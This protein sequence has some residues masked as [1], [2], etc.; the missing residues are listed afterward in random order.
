MSRRWAWIGGAC[1]GMLLV[2]MGG[3]AAA[4]IERPL[5]LAKLIEQAQDILVAKVE[6]V[7]PDRPS[8]VLIADKDLKGKTAHRRMPINLTGDKEKHTPQ[9]LK[10]VAADLPI[11]LFT[12]DGPDQIV[13]LAYTN[14]TWFQV[15]GHKDGQA[16]RWAFTHCEI[17][18]RRTYKG[19]TEELLKVLTDALAGKKQPPELD[20]NEPPGFGPELEEKPKGQARSGAAGGLLLGVV[21]LPFLMP[22]A[23]LLQLLFPGLL[24]DQW[25]QYKVAV[26]ILLTQST[27][28]FIHLALVRWV[29]SE[30]VWWLSDNAL[31]AALVTVALIGA[32]WAVAKRQSPPAVG[33]VSRPVL[34][35]APGGPSHVLDHRPVRVEYVAFGILAFAGLGWAGYLL[36]SSQ[37]P[38]DQMSVIT[39]ASL[40]GIA[41]LIYRRVRAAR[42]TCR[43]RVS[44]EAVFL[45]GLVLAGV[46]VGLY[47][48]APGEANAETDAVAADW[49]M[50][51]GN[52]QRTGSAGSSDAE[53]RKPAILWAFDAKDR[54]P[55][56]L[57]SSPVVVDGLVYV[58]ALH[59]ALSLAQGCLYC[60]NAD[61]GRLVSDRTFAAGERI[62]RFPPRGYLKPVFSS[63]SI[64]N[65][66]LYFGE[67]YHEDSGCRLFCLDARSGNQALWAKKTTS[68]VESGPCVVGNRIYFGAGDDGIYCVDADQLEPGE[69]DVPS[70][71]TLWRLPGLHV[72]S[73]P[74][75]VDDRL[76]AA[77]VIGDLHRELCLVA[78]DAGS[79][80]IVWKLPVA[81]PA[82]AAPAH[83]N[84]RV[85]F[86]LGAGKVNEAAADSRGAAICLDANGDFPKRLWEY[87]ADSAVLATPA[88]AG[89]SVF[90]CSRRG[91]CYALRQSDGH[92][93][94]KK[95][96][97]GG[98]VASPVVAGNRL[99]V[100]TT[101]GFLY[102]L[103]LADGELVWRFDE[104]KRHA[105]DDVYSSPTLVDGRL[106]LAAGGKLFC[107][108]DSGDP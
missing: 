54:M 66:R 1:F 52:E 60:V 19:T 14:G 50:F 30:Q 8:M 61:D 9:L 97:D 45:W 87:P 100:L 75:V 3:P 69:E 46:G 99:Y 72:D 65:G 11:I 37:P 85:F 70:P 4:F 34:P 79:G 64:A 108:G 18:L 5:P 80:R 67:G 88:L 28:Y 71:K 73:C 44:T 49:P 55:A 36:W 10:R 81:L 16:V 2:V 23:A 78:V 39:L 58:G 13:V 56:R 26:Y 102:C 47:F 6:K 29:F 40:V 106:Y 91:W 96:L 59:E 104:L 43:P 7:D 38:I 94:W 107:I 17:Y 51:R 103:N 89:E 90:I 83:A 22:V 63:A 62:W 92:V 101:S 95:Q 25:R 105:K 53:I 27:L 32:V 48:N 74:L 68:H 15:L 93:Q 84:G 33:R 98:V 77:T 21:A 76:F 35:A 57:D 20:K 41:H 82:A 31:W 42:L 86:A 24:R 12:L